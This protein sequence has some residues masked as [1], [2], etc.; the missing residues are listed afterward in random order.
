[1]LESTS[2]GHRVV[3]VKTVRSGSPTGAAAA[4]APA[5]TPDPNVAGDGSGPSTR[6]FWSS[7][8]CRSHR[9][10]MLLKPRQ[11]GGDVGPAPPFAYAACTSGSVLCSASGHR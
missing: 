3:D 8:Y 6:F 10:F 11:G 1:M 7:S 5:K 4:T 9:I 2:T